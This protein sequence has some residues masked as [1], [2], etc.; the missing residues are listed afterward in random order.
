MNSAPLRFHLPASPAALLDDARAAIAEGRGLLE[1]ILI[2]GK[3]PGATRTSVLFPYHRLLLRTG[4]AGAR[5]GLLSEVHPDPA[6]REAAETATQELSA[7]GTELSLNRPLYDALAALDVRTEDAVTKRWVEHTLR[8]FRRSGVDQDEPTRVRL[9]ELAQ[10]AVKLGQ[11]FD[12]NIRE[13]VRSVKL[14]PKQLA[15]LPQD[16][17][18]SHPVDAEG[19][20]TVTTDYPDLLPFRKYAEDSAARKALSFENSNRGY[21]VNEPVFTALLKVR[22]EQAT[23]LGFAH[24]AD[25]ASEDKMIKRGEN[26]ADFIEKISKLAERRAKKDYATLLER[27]RQDFPDAKDVEGFEAVYYEEKVM[28]EAL[29][30]DSQVVRPYFEFERVKKGLLDVTGKLFGIQ[31]KRVADGA[32]W[33]PDVDVYDVYEQ[34]GGT[35][36][37]LGRIY[38][39]LHPRADKYKHAA[40]FP[41]VSGV[42]GTQ[43]PEGALICNF[44]DPKV[45]S[46]ALLDHGSVV[47]FFHEFG[48]LMHH[49]LGGDVSWVSQSGVATEWDFVEAPSQMLEEWAWDPETLQSFATHVDSG[50]PIPAGLVERMRAA[51]DFGEGVRVRTQTFYAELSRRYHSEDPE[52]LDLTRELKAVQARYSLYPFAEGT[53]FY[54]SF[55]HLN[56]YSALYYTY[57]WSLVIAKDLLSVFKE[58]GLM[59]LETA[60]RYRDAVLV[61]GGTKDAAE[62]VESFLGRP[63][64][65]EAFSTWLNDGPQ[66]A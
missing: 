11:T 8:D 53:H 12:R 50:E 2:A 62:L 20:V 29:A 42:R 40:Q 38:L 26:I 18:A 9:K 27:K 43:L 30:F 19:K 32:R 37:L 35:G 22:K 55:G 57:L 31:Y 14:D 23:T 65:F 44:S 39:D 51:S 46:P 6:I 25:Y 52:T 34:G 60:G 7:F 21:P 63:Y 16:F 49:V 24:W 15:G 54:A 58:K 66:A 56:G 61:P 10:Q 59:D 36:R 13:D 5:A 17:I 64:A 48:H 4:N 47:T 33:H 3:P 28:K 45:S 1:Q 41:L